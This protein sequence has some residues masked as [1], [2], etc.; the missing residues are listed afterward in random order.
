[1]WAIAEFVG[2]LFATGIL[3]ALFSWLLG[4][5]SIAPTIVVI[6]ANALSLIVCGIGYAYGV[7]HGKAPNFAIAV[8]DF[9]PPQLFWVVVGLVRLRRRS[10]A[11]H[12]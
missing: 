3:F 2:A 8:L 4:K 5:T 10:N 1:M 11:P 12:P 6:G 7:A 9:L